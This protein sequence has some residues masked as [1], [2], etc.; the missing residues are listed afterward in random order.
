MQVGVGFMGGMWAD[1][2]PQ[3]HA[4]RTRGPGHRLLSQYA[5]QWARAQVLAMQ[6]GLEV[7][8]A[9]CQA[10]SCADRHLRGSPAG[11]QAIGMT[12][13]GGEMSGNEG[14]LVKLDA[15]A[16]F[17]QSLNFGEDAPA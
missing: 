12:I 2:N 14:A 10:G 15:I 16:A 7:A 13:F 11:L 1:H 5:A 6:L 9:E 17:R 3:C 4:Q 8:G